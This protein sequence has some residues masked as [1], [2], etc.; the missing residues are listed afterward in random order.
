M[1]ISFKD[2]IKQMQCILKGELYLNFPIWLIQAIVSSSLILFVALIC[3]S[4]KMDPSDF[5]LDY[6]SNG[7]VFLKT[8]LELL[9]FIGQVFTIIYVVKS[10]SYMSNKRKLDMYGSMPISRQVFFSGK[11]IASYIQSVMVVAALGIVVLSVGVLT[12]CD[13]SNNE[14]QYIV[15][16]M[17]YTMFVVAFYGLCI[18]C[19]K[20]TISAVISYFIIT[21]AVP[22]AVYLA[23]S[24]LLGFFAGINPYVI[25]DEGVDRIFS[26][27]NDTSLIFVLYWITLSVCCVIL[28]NF[29][30]R[31]RNLENSRRMLIVPLLEYI[32]K[33]CLTIIA[34]TFTGLFIGA[35]SAQNGAFAFIAGFLVAG[36]PVYLVIHAIYNNGFAKILRGGIVLGVLLAVS[37]TSFIIC[38]ANP[39]NFNNNV[40]NPKEILSAGFIDTEHQFKE[41]NAT[42]IIDSKN[43]FKNPEDIEKIIALHTSLANCHDEKID[44]TQKIQNVMQGLLIDSIKKALTIFYDTDYEKGY[45]ITYQYKN[46]MVNTYYYTDEYRY[47]ANET[48]YTKHLSAK[49]DI[50]A[51]TLAELEA[52]DI[53]CRNHRPVYTTSSE[54]V[55]KI[56]VRKYDNY[57]YS[58]AYWDEKSINKSEDKELFENYYDDLTK[59]LRK[60][61]ENDKNRIENNKPL[62]Y[63]LMN[64]DKYYVTPPTDRLIVSFVGNES[65]YDTFSDDY[66]IPTTYTNTIEVLERYD[67]LNEDFTVNES[68]S[69]SD[70]IDL[71]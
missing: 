26:L 52:T 5:I 68:F 54:K 29:F 18:S 58:T 39:M 38:D 21:W 67:V 69:T 45:M 70:I 61:L 15:N 33:I 43:D 62:L 25:P 37:I 51:N 3:F 36:I 28:A 49:D 65:F 53:Y 1:K 10:L 59:A 34:G 42:D 19:S 47:N 64:H 11:L 31:K 9:V 12:G 7:E 46:G 27:A 55:A 41:L 13:F 66:Y 23:K 57:Y 71:Y 40:P 17:F 2:K 35:I 6:K 22:T 4:V 44:T 48:S 8:G 32:I 63:S 56:S 16:Y 14:I 24:L 20:S 60:D 30:V 50:F